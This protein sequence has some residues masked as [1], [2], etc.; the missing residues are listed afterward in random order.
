MFITFILT[1]FSFFLF[2]FIKMSENNV[3][4][5][6]IYGGCSNN[7]NEPEVTNML[8]LGTELQEKFPSAKV[9]VVKYQAFQIRAWPETTHKFAL[10]PNFGTDSGIENFYKFIGLDGNE[11]KEHKMVIDENTL[12]IAHS[13]GCGVAAND[14]VELNKKPLAFIAMGPFMVD[15]YMQSPEF[16]KERE[17]SKEAFAY[18]LTRHFFRLR[19]IDYAKVIY[20]ERERE[21]IVDSVKYWKRAVSLVNVIKDA[22]HGLS[23]WVLKTEP[24]RELVAKICELVAA[25]VQRPDS[26]AKKQQMVAETTDDAKMD[27]Q[28]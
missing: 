18:E 17:E 5:V 22:T 26:P 21:Y 10:R 9:I 3:Q 14:L 4:H 2:F 28:Q 11:I 13:Y 23:L 6:Y 24:G 12:V 16:A 20:G 7:P 15:F 1:I 8:K 19:D 25:D 27:T